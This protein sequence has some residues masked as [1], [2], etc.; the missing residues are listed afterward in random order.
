[1]HL[2]I[3]QQDAK[4][5]TGESDPAAVTLLKAGDL[6]ITLL[7]GRKLYVCKEGAS[8]KACLT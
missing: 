1:M 7:L 6:A 3:S 8:T 4:N 5:D 2:D